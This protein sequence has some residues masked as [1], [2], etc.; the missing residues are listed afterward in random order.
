[1][2]PSPRGAFSLAEIPQ[3]WRMQ[4][5]QFVIFVLQ[6]TENLYASS[7]LDTWRWTTHLS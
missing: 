7:I 2:F 4:M 3:A 6:V 5:F 1:M